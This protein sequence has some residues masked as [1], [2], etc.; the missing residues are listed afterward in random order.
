MQR[1]CSLSHG[2]NANQQKKH[3]NTHSK[4]FTG[5]EQM[6]CSAQEQA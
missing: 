2:T 6:R 1:T 4:S 3:L 5:G